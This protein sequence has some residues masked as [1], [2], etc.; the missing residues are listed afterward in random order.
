MTQNEFVS[1]LVERN[2]AVWSLTMVVLFVYCVFF[3]PWSYLLGL[4]AFA[5]VT[6]YLML[7]VTGLWLAKF[8]ANRPL[9]Q[10]DKLEAVEQLNELARQNITEGEEVEYLK[11]IANLASAAVV[12]VSDEIVGRFLD[13]SIYAWIEMGP[14]D[15]PERYVF[16]NVA[17]R[18]RM[19]NFLPNLDGGTYAQ[20][21]GIDYKRVEPA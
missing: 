11:S 19:G 5:F 7:F 2:R 14:E 18:D 8:L 1:T 15:K 16:D 17:A 3:E 12:K 9:S 21:H 20:L 6:Y 13:N 4:A 10:A